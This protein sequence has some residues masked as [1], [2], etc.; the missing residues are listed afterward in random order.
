M[1]NSIVRTIVALIALSAAIGAHAQTLDADTVDALERFYHH[2][3]GDDWTVGTGWLDEDTPVCDWHGV[4]CG[5]SGGE[6]VLDELS[7]PSNKLSGQWHESDIS[8][9]V[10]RAVDLSG[11]AISGSL[12]TLPCHLDA[13]DLS[14]NLLSGPLPEKNHAP[15]CELSR[16]FLARNAPAGASTSSRAR[17]TRTS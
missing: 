12:P 8:E 7:L 11:N 1:K 10:E 15:P 5:N 13:L 6:P 3:N 14:D 2:F 17:S 9:W 4:Y 16:L